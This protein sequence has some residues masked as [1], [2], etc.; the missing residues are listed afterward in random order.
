VFNFKLKVPSLE[1]CKH[2]K[3]L[4]LPQDGGWYWV[5][6]R[7]SKKTRMELLDETPEQHLRDSKDYVNLYKAFTCRELVE[8]LPA[9]VEE[10]NDI[11][12]RKTDYYLCIQKLGKDFYK[13]YYKWEYNE[14]YDVI[15]CGCVEDET[16]ANVLAKMLI[17]LIENGYVK[18]EK[19]MKR[20]RSPLKKKST[21]NKGGRKN[22]S[23]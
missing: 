16:I 14:Y 5:E 17:W 12:K 10:E 21:M 15:P 11:V 8:W 3:E 2:L 4:G 7:L 20:L 9:F 1:L 23:M 22:A 13:T 6:N 19:D 18:F